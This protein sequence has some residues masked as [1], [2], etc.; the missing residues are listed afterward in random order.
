MID[1]RSNYTVIGISS[2]ALV[3]FGVL[4]RLLPHWPNFTPVTAIAL[5]GSLYLGK[6]YGIVLIL[7]SIFLSDIFL[8]FYSWPIMLSVYGSFAIIGALCSIAAKYRSVGLTS[9]LA[10][11]FPTLF[12]LITNFT[13]WLYSPWYEKTVAGLLYAYQLG[14]PFYRNMI[15]G[16]LVYLALLVAAWE[17]VLA[18][19]KQSAMQDSIPISIFQRP[20]VYP[21]KGS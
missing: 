4:M 2:L 9:A 17:T 10:L 1:F 14:L 18:F 15:I 6:R 7:G 11:I 12:F 21:Q 16:D 20:H 13:V 3:A 8:G 5:V 19:A